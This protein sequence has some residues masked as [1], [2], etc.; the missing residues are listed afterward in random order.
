M[1]DTDRNHGSGPIDRSVTPFLD[2]FPPRSSI[3][4]VTFGAQSRQGRHPVTNEDHYLI[5]ELGRHERTLRTSLPEGVIGREYDERGFA[6]VVADGMGN[7]SGGETASRL[8]IAT[9]AHLVLHFCKWNLR[10]DDRIAREVMERAERF[11]RH[12]DT[13]VMHR[14]R[15]GG[16]P[17]IQVALTAVFGAGEDLFFAHVGHARAY[18]LR[19]GALMRLTRDHTLSRGGSTAAPVAPI[20]DVN[21]TARDLKH[22]LTDTLGMSGAFGPRIDLER[23]R[24]IDRDRVLVCT[25]GVTDVVDEAVV[26]DVLAS[27]RSP[28]D[29]CRTLVDL[30]VEGG[31]D[32]D[33]TALIAH[34]VLPPGDGPP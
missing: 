18:L 11:Y 21:A 32:D 2:P 14:G 15:T 12:V 27:G 19:E 24:I 4:R 29:Q 13:A 20:M 8:A 5:V 34:F 26:A 1:A 6:M 33:A 23:F 17:R 9:L 25:N 22:I 30:A 7:G 3:T 16:V 10:I 31:G 28:E